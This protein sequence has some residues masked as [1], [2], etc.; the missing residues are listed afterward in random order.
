MSIELLVLLAFL[1]LLPLIQSLLAAAR[2]RDPLAE[3]AAQPVPD[4]NA[5]EVS[6][7]P[8]RPRPGPASAVLQ[9]PEAASPTARGAESRAPRSAGPVEAEMP[10]SSTRRPVAVPGLRNR[11]DLGR[12][13]V[14][15]AILGPCRGANPHEWPEGPARP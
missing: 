10:R 13:M 15:M 4:P 5:G 8:A 3:G 7:S 9:L 14:L 1:V 12:A 6:R 2:P 11:L